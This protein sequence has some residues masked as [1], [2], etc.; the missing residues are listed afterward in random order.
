MDYEQIATIVVAV[1][2]F[3]S[4]C[5]QYLP[6]SWTEKIPDIAMVIINAIAAKHGSAD[7][8]KTDMKGNSVE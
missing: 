4:H 5:V 2:Y 8:A 6:V 1:A 3:L 7:A